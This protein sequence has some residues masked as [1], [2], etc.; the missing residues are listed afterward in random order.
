MKNIEAK[1]YRIIDANFNRSQ[2]GLRVCEEITRFILE[3]KPLTGSIKSV[4]HSIAGLKQD[5]VSKYGKG[6]AEKLLHGPRNSISDVG[7]GL[8]ITN[9]AKRSGYADVF[10]ANIER[11]KESLRV[12]EEFSKLIDARIAAS[13][14]DLRFTVYDVEKKA[15]SKIKSLRHL[16]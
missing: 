6:S 2:E 11:V 9:E 1:I 12:L 3:S 16:R 14:L 10:Y 15:F 13:F 7:R 4:R 8:R 5:I